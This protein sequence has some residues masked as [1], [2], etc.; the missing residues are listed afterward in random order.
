MA[1]FF[2]AAE[3]IS[4]IY[5][6]Q[7][8]VLD[9]V[10][11]NLTEFPTVP[12]DLKPQIDMIYAQG[13]QFDTL[14]DLHEYTNLFAIHCGSNPNFGV[15]GTPIRTLHRFPALEWS[16]IVDL[17]EDALDQPFRQFYQTFQQTGDY[18]AFRQVLDMYWDAEAA[19]I[20]SL[21]QSIQNLNMF[22]Q[23][24]VPRNEGGVTRYN[25]PQNTTLSRLPGNLSE[26]LGS[27]LSGETGTIQQQR[28]KL[29]ELL[30]RP[31]GGLGVGGR[32][33]TRKGS[34]RKSRKSSKK[35]RTRVYIV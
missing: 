3:A 30:S 12:N 6:S 1:R 14:P 13:N 31:R 4:H 20:Q 34:K 25:F 28:L 32:R 26:V 35:Y 22:R 9:L 2:S 16:P 23:S 19:R 29:Q 8:P 10:D 27:Y 17:D 11:L 5:E 33:K 15:V 18:N 21:Q 7:E 24:L